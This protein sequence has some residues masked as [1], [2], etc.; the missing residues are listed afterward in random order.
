[1]LSLPWKNKRL[2]LVQM[3]TKA[4]LP[5][6]D[7][8][9]SIAAMHA[10]VPSAMYSALSLYYHMPSACLLVVHA[11]WP[12]LLLCTFACRA[13]HT[14]HGMPASGL[15]A[16]LCC[17]MHVHVTTCAQ[18]ATVTIDSAA[19]YAAG[20]Q[21]QSKLSMTGWSS[22]QMAASRSITW[23]APRAF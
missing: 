3:A 1:M 12:L 6:V 15:M 23:T 4:F 10:V 11:S 22:M 19:S 2:F 5:Q 21:Q 20:S 8:A 9:A 17:C 16:Q 13:G 18:R 7:A 14:A